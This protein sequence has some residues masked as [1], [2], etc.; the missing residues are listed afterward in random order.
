MTNNIIFTQTIAFTRLIIK[1]RFLSVRN[2]TMFT[3]S[4]EQAA[5]IPPKK[6]DSEL[7][8]RLEDR[9]P[10]LQSRGF[11]LFSW[12]SYEGNRAGY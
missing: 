7:I 8:Y 11:C 12:W 9:P 3:S 4:P 1:M 6:P 2:F 10:L 5:T